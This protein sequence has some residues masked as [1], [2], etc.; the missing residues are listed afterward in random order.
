MF[1]AEAQGPSARVHD[2]GASVETGGIVSAK[3]DFAFGQNKVLPTRGSDSN[4][5]IDEATIRGKV[6]VE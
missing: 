4:A 1:S 2:I 6:F 3:N 5:P